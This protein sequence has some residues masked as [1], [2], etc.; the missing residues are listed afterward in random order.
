M[1]NKTVP[2]PRG[3]GYD[4]TPKGFDDGMLQFFAQHIARGGMKI[5]SKDFFKQGKTGEP[6]AE[7]NEK[8][9]NM[10]AEEKAKLEAEQKRQAFIVH[11]K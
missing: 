5:K 8:L 9:A 11:E 1:D 6:A 7:L 3:N 10:V 4:D 2:F